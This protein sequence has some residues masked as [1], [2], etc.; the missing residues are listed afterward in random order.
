MYKNVDEIYESL[1]KTRGKLFST[2]ESVTDEQTSARENGAGWSISEIAEHVA[3]VE[4]GGLRI[5]QK[6]LSAAEQIGVPANDALNIPPD[7]TGKLMSISDRKLEAPERIYPQGNQTLEE[8][9]AALKAR[10]SELTDLRD[11]LQAVDASQ[12]TFPH[13]F[14]GE[15][16]VYQ[17]MIMLGLHEQRHLAQINRILQNN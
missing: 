16:N 6:L 9:L 12:P 15:M 14:L 13:P 3:L 5:S 2:L 17:W 11:R 10:R 1:E 4:E 7:F 8:S